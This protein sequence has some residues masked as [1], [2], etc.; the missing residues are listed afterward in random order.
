MKGLEATVWGSDR[1][2]T[3]LP[4]AKGS[5]SGWVEEKGLLRKAVPLPV[6][7]KVEVEADGRKGCWE[8]GLL[9]LNAIEDGSA[10]PA[11]RFW[12]GKIIDIDEVIGSGGRIEGGGAEGR[13][14]PELCTW[15]RHKGKRR[16]YPDVPFACVREPAVATKI[17]L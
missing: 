6:G 11:G 13:P 1:V 15:M 17:T 2:A 12:G 8:K 10:R 16:V 4:P 5:G 7:S 14:L 9:W 3:E